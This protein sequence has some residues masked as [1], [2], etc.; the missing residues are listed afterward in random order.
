MQGGFMDFAVAAFLRHSAGRLLRNGFL[1]AVLVF[2]VPGAGADAADGFAGMAVTVVKT[3]TAC[4]DDSIA[5]TGFIL[6]REVALVRPDVDGYH[7][8]RVLKEDGDIVEKGDKL[9]DLVKPDWLPPQVPSTASV[10]ANA[11]G[12]LIISR[13]IPIGMPVARTQTLFRIIRNGEFDLVVDIPQVHLRKIKSGQSV[14]IEM[15]GAADIVGTVRSLDTDIDFLSQ[16]GHARVQITGKPNLRA[17]TFAIATIDANHRCSNPSVPLSAVLFGP[18]GSIVRVVRD[19][20]I[21]DRSVQ[22]GLFGDKNIEILS[23]LKIDDLVVARA[24]AFLH[25]RDPVRPILVEIQETS[26]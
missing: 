14:R 19:G 5:L 1:A 26:H 7:V 2:V 3:K 8:L 25:E 16:L 21:E 20:H 23:G 18:Q 17:G 22:I 4:F 15:L 10:A 24:G 12:I 9:L 6:P 13:P 11:S